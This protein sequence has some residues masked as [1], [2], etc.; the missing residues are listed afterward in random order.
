MTR[1]ATP[2]PLVIAAVVVLFA[3]LAVRWRVWI[4]PDPQP[5]APEPEATE[6]VPPGIIVSEESIPS[7]GGKGAPGKSDLAGYAAPGGTDTADMSMLAG[8]ASAFLTIHKQAAERPLSA[9]EEW[10]AAL[11]GQRPG[12]TRW[13]DDGPPVFSTD[14]KIIDRHGTP[15]HFH[16]LGHKAWEF[17]SAGPD[18][19]LFTDDDAVSAIGNER[20]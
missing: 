9:N 12:T 4:F 6:I 18:K 20:R 10:S 17:R 14:G 19:L 3:V 5:L 13:L 1:R 8:S 11:R 7:G 2:W 16:A 15:V